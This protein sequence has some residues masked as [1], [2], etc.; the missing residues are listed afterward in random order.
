MEKVLLVTAYGE[1]YCQDPKFEVNIIQ[2][3][4]LIRMLVEDKWAGTSEYINVIDLLDIVVN[5]LPQIRWGLKEKPMIDLLKERG[6]VA[7]RLCGVVD[8]DRRKVEIAQ[9]ITPDEY[10]L[11]KVYNFKVDG[12]GNIPITC[13]SEPF[14]P[15]IVGMIALA[16]LNDFPKSDPRYGRIKALLT[17]NLGLPERKF[18]S[19]EKEF[20]TITEVLNEDFVKL[21]DLEDE[22]L[23]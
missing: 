5:I 2:H 7:A 22:F 6:I 23:P 14:D 15:I 10:A 17:G 3:G 20:I 19:F 12:S 4:D 8:G 1:E 9:R 21:E 11:K 16:R 18:K 13:L